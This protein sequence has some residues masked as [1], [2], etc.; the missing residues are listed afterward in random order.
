MAE[1]VRWKKNIYVFNKKHNLDSR[2][3]YL[4]SKIME[5]DVSFKQQLQGSQS[6]YTNIRKKD[7]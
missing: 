1:I 3:R 7:L 2:H 4:E 6:G 5:K